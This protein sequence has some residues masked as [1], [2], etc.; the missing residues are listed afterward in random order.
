MQRSEALDNE[1]YKTLFNLMAVLADRFG[2][3][4]VRLVVFFD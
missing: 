1:G 2:N 3:E 4:K